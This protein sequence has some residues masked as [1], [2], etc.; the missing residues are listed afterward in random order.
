M[1][2]NLNHLVIN[3]ASDARAKLIYGD[4]VEAVA[5]ISFL[6]GVLATLSETFTEVSAIY[7]EVNRLSVD[8]PNVQLVAL[9]DNLEDRL[10]A[11]IKDV[12]QGN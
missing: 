11:S 5:H 7:T 1:Y 10:F 4:K 2:Q 3:H 6:L 9:L 12:E 8:V